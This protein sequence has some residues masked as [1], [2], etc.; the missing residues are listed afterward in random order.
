M[1]VSVAI[2]LS[3]TDKSCVS[4]DIVVISEITKKTTKSKKISADGKIFVFS[5]V[6]ADER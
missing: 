3:K 6:L 4:K 2:T 5:K 1:S